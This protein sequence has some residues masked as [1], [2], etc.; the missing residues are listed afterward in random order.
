MNTLAFLVAT[1]LWSSMSE[2]A[3]IPMFT[4]EGQRFSVEVLTEQRDVIWGFDFLD[5]NR[6]IFTER[7]GA[8]KILS[9]KDKKIT[10]ITGAPKV[11]ANGQGGLLDVRVSPVNRDQIYLTY[12]EPVGEDEA[13]TALGVG[14]LKGSELSGFKKLF[15]ANAPSD[16]TIHFGSRVEFDG[17]GHLFFAIGDRN[18]RP[19]VQDLSFHNGKMIRLKMDGSIPADNPLVKTSNAKPEIWSLGHRSPQGLVRDPKTGDLWEAEMGPRGGDELNFIEP[20]KNYGWP[21]VTYGREYSGFPL[22]VKEK[23][24][25]TQPVAHWVPSISP[26]AIALYRGKKIQKWDGNIFVACLSGMHI[27]RLVL[28]D[29]KVVKEEELLKSLNYRFRNIR[30]GRDENLYFSTDS[31][32]IGRLILAPHSGN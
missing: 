2:A 20:G 29:R 11:F 16:E 12:S 32:V 23:V 21:E 24:G 1:F 7:G 14:T 17:K 13:T 3:D 5:E 22:G 15:S 31:G 6:V 25:M 18:A 27:R 9:L 28:S 10:S 4:S 19:K 30:V 8:L 26:S